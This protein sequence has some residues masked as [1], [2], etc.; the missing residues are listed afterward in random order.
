MSTSKEQ[1]KAH[2]AD[3]GDILVQKVKET[4]VIAQDAV[5]SGGWLYPLKGIAYFATHP[6][7]YKSIA[8]MLKKSLFI[9]VGV[10]TAMFIFTYLP[11]VALCALFTGPL[12]FIAAATLVMGESYAIILFIMK[13]FMFGQAHDQIFDA[14]LLQQGHEQL[15]ARGRTIKPSGNSGV[16][17]LEQSILKPLDRFSKDGI[18]RYLLSLPLN[19]V[20]VVGTVFF[21]G[22]NGIKAG[23]SFHSR[24]FQLKGWDK[25][26]KD[27][28][29]EQRKGAYTA[30]GAA[31]LALNLV[32]FVG[33]LFGFTSTAGAA[34]WASDM[35][36]QERGVKIGTD[37]PSQETQVE[38]S[39]MESESQQN[40]KKML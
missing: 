40:V 25:S 24:Y 31:S 9:S 21:L 4:S 30:F 35:E 36:K 11:Q 17:K 12:A 29:V 5:T 13:G 6:S 26:K 3:A 7:L 1:V 27:T 19:A 37:Q 14:V 28:F 34:L 32:P 8:P 33:L 22:F 39:P 2:A 16:K 38:F 10:I 18:I 23:P 20:P 15:V